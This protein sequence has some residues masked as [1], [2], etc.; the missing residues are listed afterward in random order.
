MLAEGEEEGDDDMAE[1]AVYPPSCDK[2]AGETDCGGAALFC[3][4]ISSC[5]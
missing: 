4:V 3:V 2:E 1:M 5:V